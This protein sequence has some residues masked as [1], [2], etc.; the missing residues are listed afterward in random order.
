MSRALATAAL[1]ASLACRAAEAPVPSPTPEPFSTA[2]V[3]TPPGFRFA[4]RLTCKTVVATHP[5]LLMTHEMRG[6]HS[7]TATFADKTSAKT[8]SRVHD[9]PERV[10]FQDVEAAASAVD[11]ISIDK[12]TGASTRTFSG[13]SNEGS[14]LNAGGQR[15]YCKALEGS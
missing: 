7:S 2:K 14:E 4:D 3:P 11:T 13:W 15:G 12:T 8:M 10:V 5:A 1:L 9:A 6:V